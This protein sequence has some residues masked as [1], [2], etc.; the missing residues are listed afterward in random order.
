MLWPR[1]RQREQSPTAAS[2]NDPDPIAL[3][4]L[5]PRAIRQAITD[6]HHHFVEHRHRTIVRNQ[7]CRQTACAAP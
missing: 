7:N 4:G 2:F 6:T 3:Y 5:D 1:R